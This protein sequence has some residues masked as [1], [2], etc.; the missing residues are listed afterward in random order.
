M[1]ISDYYGK[2]AAVATIQRQVDEQLDVIRRNKSYSDEGRNAEMAKVLFAARARVAEMKSEVAADRETRRNN[3]HRIVFGV[4]GQPSAFDLIATRDAQDRASRIST[5]DEAMAM[6]H[7]ANQTGDETL[8]KATAEQAFD[9][10]WTDVANKYADATGK[11]G[12]LDR[13]AEANEGRYTR[14]ADAIVFQ[15]RN[16]KELASATESTLRELAN[17][18]A[19]GMEK[20]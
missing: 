9:K 7:R 5:I 3:L 18:H 6:L 17:V 10:G 12:A 20:D 16:P 8:A 19:P 2:K 1:P 4:V 11:R 14:L 15:I 13:L